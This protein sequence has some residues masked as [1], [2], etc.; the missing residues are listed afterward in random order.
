[1][2]GECWLTKTGAYDS[3]SPQIL[4]FI[5]HRVLLL[6]VTSSNLIFGSI[7]IIH[8]GYKY[9]RC[10]LLFLC[11]L[12]SGDRLML[13]LRYDNE[14]FPR[15]AKLGFAVESEGWALCFGSDRA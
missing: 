9:R 14:M 12:G 10:N 6:P 13:P 15:L 11:N 2:I 1:M 4:L 5:G 3:A 8:Q 7:L